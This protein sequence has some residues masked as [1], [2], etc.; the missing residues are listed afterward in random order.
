MNHPLLHPCA[1]TTF[2]MESGFTNLPSPICRHQTNAPLGYS[3]LA[4]FSSL[5][6]PSWLSLLSSPQKRPVGRWLE[7][8]G[9][10]SVHGPSVA[11]RSLIF[12]DC[13]R[14]SASHN[15]EFAGLNS[16]CPLLMS[17][18]FQRSHFR[19][20]ISSA[21]LWTRTP[22]CRETLEG[23]ISFLA[24]V[25]NIDQLFEAFLTQESLRIVAIR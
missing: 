21:V 25:H 10:R 2:S 1:A 15:L 22:V 23:S 19:F 9:K 14:C 11:R 5:V 4:I 13:L 17:A 12:Y 3:A 16:R 24:E 20:V 6:A 8:G 18:N 7:N